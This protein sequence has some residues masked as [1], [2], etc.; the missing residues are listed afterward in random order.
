MKMFQ[1]WDTPSIPPDVAAWMQELKAQNPEYDHRLYDRQGAAHYIGSNIGERERAAFLTCAVPAGQ[2]DYFRL[3]VLAVE[4]G[5]YLDADTQPL[6]PL[7]T[8]LDDIPFALVCT[9]ANALNNSILLFRAAGHPLLIDGLALATD[10]IENRRFD[11]V[12]TAVGPSVL[13]AVHAAIDAERR[14]AILAA[15]DND[16][17]K[18]NGF[19]ELMVVADQII[20]PSP[21]KLAAFRKITTFH[22]FL[23]L[24]WIGPKQPDYKS[25]P[26]HWVNWKGSIYL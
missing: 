5:L 3:C 25:T 1:Y 13:N 9:Y 21:E 2:A 6:K 16:I 17:S 22:V 10:N 4:G 7:S 18:R 20:E 24:A 23:T 19:D 15:H 14:S 8:L 11:T 12:F 26:R